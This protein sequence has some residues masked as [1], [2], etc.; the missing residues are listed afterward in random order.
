M[1][2]NNIQLNH[3]K[4]GI[5]IDINNND[6]GFV[7]K[8]HFIPTGSYTVEFDYID[9]TE[10]ATANIITPVG[11]FTLT[12][13]PDSLNKDNT[14]DGSTDPFGVLDFFNNNGFSF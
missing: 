5:R 6:N 2:A 7:Q 11:T 10:A 12:N 8:T 1:P 9:N 13:N 4:N 14:F 3:V